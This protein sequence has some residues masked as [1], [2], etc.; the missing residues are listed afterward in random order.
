MRSRCLRASRRA[1]H[2]DCDRAAPGF[3]SLRPP[4]LGE[5]NLCC[6]GQPAYGV[7][8]K[9]P[10]LGHTD[11]YTHT[12]TDTTVVVPGFESQFLHLTSTNHVTRNDLLSSSVLHSPRLINRGSSIYPTG[13]L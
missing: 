10:K 7:L 4:E 12:H 6:L 8:L 2:Q 1:N 3:Q 13:L 9:Q 5:I 11:I